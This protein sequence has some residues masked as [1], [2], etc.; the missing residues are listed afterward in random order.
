MHG[1]VNI[2]NV[3]LSFKFGDGPTG[4]PE[5][6]GRNYQCTLRSILDTADEARRYTMACFSGRWRCGLITRR[7]EVESQMENWLFLC[8]FLE[9][10]SYLRRL[11]RKHWNEA[12]DILSRGWS[13]SRVWCEVLRISVAGPLLHQH[14]FVACAGMSL[15]YRFIPN[16]FQSIT[17][18]YMIDKLAVSGHAL[19][20][21]AVSRKVAGSI[22]DGGRCNLSVT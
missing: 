20:H 19:A 4:C 7:S 3:P 13:L 21:C 2:K 8:F 17:G 14:V 12:L 5:T 6:S 9:F 15:P 16:R 11:S 18:L 22:P 1:H 10:F